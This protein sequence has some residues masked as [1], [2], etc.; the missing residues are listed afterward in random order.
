MTQFD[1]ETRFDEAAGPLVRPYTVSGGRTQPAAD[2]RLITIVVT[3]GRPL[4]DLS[5]EHD[6][7]LGMCRRPVSVAE[8]SARVRL[9]VAVI[10]ILLADLLDWRAIITRAPIPFTERARPDRQ[11]L[12]A[13]LHGLRNL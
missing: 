12:E 7:I 5:P 9:P 3:T 10:K 2:L 11:V 1:P 8:V 4:G 6:E 13:V